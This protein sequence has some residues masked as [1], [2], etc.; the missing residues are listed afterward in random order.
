[1]TFLR[2]RLILAALASGAAAAGLAQ[3]YRDESGASYSQLEGGGYVNEDTVRT[4]RETVSHSIT[5]PDWTNPA[6]FEKDVF[7]FARIIFRSDPSRAEGFGWGRRL[8]WWVDYPDADLNLSHRLQQ[9]TSMAV[10]PDARVLKLTNPDLFDF[11][12]IF[13]EH[14][15]GMVL[16][17]QEVAILREYLLAGGSMLVTDFWGEEAWTHFKRQIREVVPEHDWVELATD[18]PLFRSVFQIEGPMHKL[19]VP[20]LQFWN[21]RADPDDPEANL[22]DR[23]RG[24]G[25]ERMHV[26]ALLDDRQ[27]I[28]AVAVHNSDISDGWEREGE[29]E[30]YFRRFS[31][32]RAYPLAIN[33]IFYLM[34]H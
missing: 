7:T 3:L 8:G 22:S 21:T 33:I 19:R 27:R 32:P 15:E 24:E 25:A 14:V 26:W 28:M 29:N 30:T 18:H 10:D 23:W 12:L 17:A 34:T 16:S 5:L 2:P 1:M 20:T 6:G 11:P 13:M 9:M 31:E 4:A